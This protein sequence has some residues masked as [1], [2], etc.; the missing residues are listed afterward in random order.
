MT[1]RNDSF[2]GY[3]LSNLLMI[4]KNILRKIMILNDCFQSSS[5][6]NAHEFIEDALQVRVG[7]LNQMGLVQIKSLKWLFVVYPH[8]R[9]KSKMFNAVLTCTSLYEVKP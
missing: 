3:C 7:F 9:L 1:S 2:Y 5:L 4:S 6:G 8:F